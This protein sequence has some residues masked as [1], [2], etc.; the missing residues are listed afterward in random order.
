MSSTRG[1]NGRTSGSEKCYGA[2]VDLGLSRNGFV[3]RRED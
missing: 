2:E 3:P 1:Q